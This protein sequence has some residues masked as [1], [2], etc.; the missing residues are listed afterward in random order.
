MESLKKL[1]LEAN[2]HFIENGGK[3]VYNLN[4]RIF[5]DYATK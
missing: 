1:F 4:C 5:C 2:E 3:M